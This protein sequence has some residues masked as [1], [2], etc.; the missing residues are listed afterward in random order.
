[1][2]QPSE[3]TQLRNLKAEHAVMKKELFALRE[4]YQ[5]T[6]M[7]LASAATERD[8]WKKRFDLLLEKCGKLDP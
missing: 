8:E 4:K 1:M 6:I 3:A 2:R 7:K 5:A